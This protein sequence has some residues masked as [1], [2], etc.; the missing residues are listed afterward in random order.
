MNFKLYLFTDSFVKSHKGGLERGIVGVYSMAL[1]R[2]LVGWVHLVD[3]LVG[4]ATPEQGFGVIWGELET[5]EINGIQNG[6]VE[7]A[8]S[9]N[10]S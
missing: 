2:V 6:F 9:S 3:R 4:L 1:A 8:V 10:E 5:S 7:Q